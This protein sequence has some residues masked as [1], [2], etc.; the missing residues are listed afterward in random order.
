MQCKRTQSPGMDSPRAQQASIAD[1]I[2]K[3]KESY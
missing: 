2:A 1:I 3:K